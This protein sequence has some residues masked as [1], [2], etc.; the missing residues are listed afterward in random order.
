MQHR[1]HDQVGGRKAEGQQAE[2]AAQEGE[3]DAADGG[4]GDQHHQEQFDAEE[5]RGGLAP[6]AQ[7]QRARFLDGL[8]VVTH[9]DV[10]AIV[11][12]GGNAKSPAGGDLELAFYH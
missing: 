11:L 4:E 9:D 6:D 8:D 10:F 1:A 3:E 7:Q 5:K 2:R 12:G